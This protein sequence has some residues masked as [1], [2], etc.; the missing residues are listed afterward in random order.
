METRGGSEG[1]GNVALVTSDT[2]IPLLAVGIRQ[3]T[4]FPA[5]AHVPVEPHTHDVGRT[6]SHELHKV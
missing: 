3:A 4:K 1:G 6:L 2:L 5:A